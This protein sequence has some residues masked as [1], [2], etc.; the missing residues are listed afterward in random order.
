MKKHIRTKGYDSR[1]GKAEPE[2]SRRNLNQDQ[3]EGSGSYY[4]TRWTQWR[5]DF[6]EVD[7]MVREG[8]GCSKTRR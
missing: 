7:R 2:E 6:W 4:N 1:R 5:G 3:E 8:T